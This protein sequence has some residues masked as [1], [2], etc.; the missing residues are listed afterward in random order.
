MGG[1]YTFSF[2][3]VMMAFAVG[4]VLLQVGTQRLSELRDIWRR[5][6]RT[7]YS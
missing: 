3:L 7:V 4:V 5:S 2:L 6:I 1:I